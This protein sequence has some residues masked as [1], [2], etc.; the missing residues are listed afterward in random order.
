MIKFLQMVFI[1]ARV[2]IKYNQ[3]IISYKKRRLTNEAPLKKVTH[4]FILP[5]FKESR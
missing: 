4:V 1:L 3:S 5:N 2:Y